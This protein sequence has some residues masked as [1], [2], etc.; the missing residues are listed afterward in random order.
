LA[1]CLTLAGLS[2][3][4]YS[5]VTRFGFVNF[6]DAQYINQNPIVL[7]G[8]TLDGVRWSFTSGYAGN[9]FPLTWLSHMLDV[10]LFGAN[11]GAQHTVNVALHVRRV[12]L[13]TRPAAALR[14]AFL[15]AELSRVSE[16]GG[17]QTDAGREAAFG[18][19]DGL[20]AICL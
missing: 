17:L 18:I 5:P 2:A 11:T 10:S 20:R 9:W 7:R 12:R 14:R 16:L 19:A 8:L 6:D 4:V 13:G 15:R 1:I 3:A